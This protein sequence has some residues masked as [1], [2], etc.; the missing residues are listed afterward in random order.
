[1]AILVTGAT[2]FIGNHVIEELLRQ[3]KNVIATSTNI[4]KA[5]KFSWFLKVDFIE[6]TIAEEV[7]INL[8]EY[9]KKP[10]AIIHLAWQGLPNYKALFH[11]EINLVNDYFF[12]KNLVVNGLK[13]ITITGTCFEYG[14]KSG[15]IDASF[16]TDPQNSY[17]VAKDTLRKM[18]QLLQLEQ[19]FVLKWT[20]LF[21]MYGEGQSSKSILAQLATA[22]ENGDE[23]FKMSKG[24]QLRDYLPVT[25][26]ASKIVELSTNTN[27]S[28]VT[29]CCSG[30]PISILELVKNFR[31]EKKSNIKLNL[32]YYPYPDYE[33]MEFW[34]IV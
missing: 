22:I 18:L 17:A 7:D 31:E 1:M 8:F 12:I 27:S 20:R 23:S 9:F 5:K 15:A 21:Y 19:S 32:G 34:G 2:G 29:N 16:N 3:G 30:V 4:E 13:D 14:M 33:P 25:K 11:I 26:V 6:F 24:E 10:E 28:V